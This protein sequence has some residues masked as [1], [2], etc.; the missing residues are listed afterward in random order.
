MAR[1]QISVKPQ[2]QESGLLLPRWY[3]TSDAQ[4]VRKQMRNHAALKKESHGGRNG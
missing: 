2:M 1:E 3:F 4:A